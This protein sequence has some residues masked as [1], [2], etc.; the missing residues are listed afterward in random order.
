MFPQ[1]DRCQEAQCVDQKLR[2]GVAQHQLVTHGPY[3]DFALGG[4]IGIDGVVFGLCRCFEVENEFEK[5]RGGGFFLGFGILYFKEKESCVDGFYDGKG[6]V[7]RLASLQ[8]F[9]GGT[10]RFNDDGTLTEDFARRAEH[11]LGW[12]K[13]ISENPPSHLKSSDFEAEKELERWQ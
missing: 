2:V 9:V 10:E 13:G 11:G 8:C 1:L 4:K 12:R 5:R 3:C 6:G 7:H